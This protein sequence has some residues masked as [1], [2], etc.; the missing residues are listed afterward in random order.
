MDIGQGAKTAFRI[1]KSS[2]GAAEAVSECEDN[3]MS[4]G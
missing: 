3:K 1:D 2:L 4:G